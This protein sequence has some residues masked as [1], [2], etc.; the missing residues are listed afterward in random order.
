MGVWDLR[1]K[2]RGYYEIRVD[3]VPAIDVLFLNDLAPRRAVL[4]RLFVA[5]AA[6]LAKGHIAPSAAPLAAPRAPEPDWRA[7]GWQG[8]R[9]HDETMV[10]L[11]GLQARWTRA[12][13]AAQLDRYVT[14]QRAAAGIPDRPP[15]SVDQLAELAKIIDRAPSAVHRAVAVFADVVIETEKGR[16][17]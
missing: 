7:L 2:G 6:R 9:D 11:E 5:A 12:R 13:Q 10:R 15:Y 3:G 1:A 14:E 8:R 16:K 4:L 17:A